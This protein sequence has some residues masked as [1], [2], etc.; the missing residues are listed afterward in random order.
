MSKR[1]GYGVDYG[2]IITMQTAEDMHSTM[3]YDMIADKQYSTAYLIGSF[4]HNKQSTHQLQTMRKE[5]QRN[6]HH[7]G[8][9]Y[10]RTVH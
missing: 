2:L 7:T 3:P 4:L 1:N 8:L 9:Y 10:K 6:P 5:I